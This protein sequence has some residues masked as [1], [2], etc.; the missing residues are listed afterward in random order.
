[1]NILIV[2]DSTLEMER[3]VRL[4]H[5]AVPDAKLHSFTDSIQARAAILQRGFSPDV[6]FLDIE[7][8]APN[9]IELAGL[10][11]ET[12]PRVNIIYTTAYSSYM[13]QA[14]DM[15]VSGY[16]LKPFSLKD[17]QNQLA[18]LRYPQQT[19]GPAYFAQTIGN[20][21]FFYQGKPVSFP[22]SKSKEALAY[23]IDRR[24]SSVTKRELFSILF[25]DRE[26]TR[27]KQDHVKKIMK[28]LKI[29]LEEI[30][31][32]ELLL[33]NRNAYAVDMSRI[34][35]DLAEADQLDTSTYMEQ[36]AWADGWRR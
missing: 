16:L 15:F 3:I 33:H 20:F 19:T 22:L 31:G 12:C 18:H 8:P 6:A 4:V 34:S 10:L 5:E 24:G 36:Y 25:E 14:L 23:L 32:G 26:Y 27:T 11:A 13:Q 1:M 29:A 9:G 28:A 17:I 21:D 35:T 2:E 30:G 7:M